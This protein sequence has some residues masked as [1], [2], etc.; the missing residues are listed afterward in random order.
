MDYVNKDTNMREI[1]KFHCTNLTLKSQKVFSRQI[2][3]SEKH[4]INFCHIP[5]AG[6]SV[7]YDLFQS[8]LEGKSLDKLSEL[9]QDL[10]IKNHRSLIYVR[11]PLYRLFSAYNDKVIGQNWYYVKFIGEWVTQVLRGGMRPGYSPCYDDVTFEDFIKMVITEIK[12]DTNFV[13]VHWSP[14]HMLCRPCDIHY[15]FIG[16]LET[17]EQDIYQLSEILA[18][19]GI[20]KE[21]LIK[22]FEDQY[23]S[24]KCREMVLMD[25]QII[26]YKNYTCDIYDIILRKKLEALWNKGFVESLGFTFP[27]FRVLHHTKWRQTCEKLVNKALSEPSK[28]KQVKRIANLKAQTAIKSLPP[29]ILDQLLEIF[30]PDFDMFGY[31]FDS[32]VDI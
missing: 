17:E 15:N 2:I 25:S 13:D 3:V 21:T 24:E 18:T 6:S 14:Y 27:T 32:F 9:N 8:Q 20:N 28:R 23:I 31:E 16:K 26:L 12:D 1:L 22:L 4:K 30:R 10:A 29:S 19:A 7:V 11:N 5:K